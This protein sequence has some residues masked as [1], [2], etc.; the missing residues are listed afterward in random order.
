V[1]GEQG[2][3]PAEPG[4]VVADPPAGQQLSVPVHQGD[5]VMIFGPVDPAEYVHA[6]L[7]RVKSLFTAV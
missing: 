1:L 7:L 5:V 2:Q 4:R 3:Q 6:F